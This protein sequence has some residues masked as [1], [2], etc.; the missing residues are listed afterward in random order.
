M[1]EETVRFRRITCN[2]K[3]LQTFTGE[4]VNEFNQWKNNMISQGAKVAYDRR[5]NIYCVSPTMDFEMYYNYVLYINSCHKEWVNEGYF[6]CGMVPYMMW[7]SFM[8]ASPVVDQMRKLA[9]SVGMDMISVPAVSFLK[10][11]YVANGQDY[12]VFRNDLFSLM[13]VLEQTD[14]VYAFGVH[15]P[16]E[17]TLSRFLKPLADITIRA[18][19]GQA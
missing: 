9:R 12:W 13:K 15:N 2:F 7:P 10:N 18:R 4:Q 14:P 5:N 11:S 17:A 8:D 3:R 16:D 19:G 1:S 6:D